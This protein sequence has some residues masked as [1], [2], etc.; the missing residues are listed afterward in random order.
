MMPKPLVAIVGRPNVGKSTLFNRIIGQRLAIVDDRPGT[1]RDRLYAD[2]DWNGV[3]FTLVDTGG[4]DLVTAQRETTRRTETMHEYNPA[5]IQELVSHQAQVAIAEADVI[6]FVAATTEGITAGDLDVAEQ[7]RRSHKPLIL[8]ANKADNLKRELDA[9]E[10]YQFG[11][12]E[13]HVISAL[14]G[15]GTGDLLDKIVES[16]P[17]QPVVAETDELKIAIVGRPNVGKSSLLNAL[18]GQERAIVSDIPGTT[19]DSVDTR[20]T[21]K[22]EPIT[23]IDTAG[24]R[25]RGHIAHG[26]VEQYS[27]LRALRAIQRCN[28]AL[29]LIDAADGVTAQDAHVA[30]YILEEGK[31][32]VIVVNKWDLIEKE[33]DTLAIFERQVRK[34]LDFMAWA[35]IEFVSARTKRRIGNT[36]DAAIHVREAMQRRVP[37][38][39]LNELVREATARHS[40]PSR[41]GKRLRFF[42]ATQP[43]VEPPL[44]V[45]FVNDHTLVHFS[46]QRY[47]ENLVRE[48]W[49][50]GGTPIRMAFR[51]RDKE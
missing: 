27:V 13:P 2:A 38:G 34:A 9:V 19:R 1:T 40:P 20:I 47:L 6:V 39:E 37:T 16:I 4:L 23:L 15:N 8:V 31:G 45:F 3:E 7:L 32:A 46:Y 24:I 51:Q 18:I 42:Y 48:R 49:D 50:F 11:L 41:H 5:Q 43:S 17:P 26:E 21:W 33:A 35:P 44:L 22:D 25:R 29:L 28:V 36:L 10:F 30:Q 14:H 12:G